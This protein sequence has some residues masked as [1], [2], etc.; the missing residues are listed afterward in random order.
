MHHFYL[1]I[2]CSSNSSIVYTCDFAQTFRWS[3]PVATN[4]R[5]TSELAS[6]S[7]H[8][9]T[10]PMVSSADSWNM[11]TSIISCSCFACKVHEYKVCHIYSLEDWIIGA[12]HF[13]TPIGLLSIYQTTES[14]W[15]PQLGGLRWI[16]AG[17]QCLRPCTDMRQFSRETSHLSRFIW[18]ATR[19][20]HPAYMPS[21]GLNLHR[22]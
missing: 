20:P 2:Y 15:Q 9:T 11:K 13:T 19:L 12:G 21:S 1:S 7:L 4:P 16:H 10:C 22:L 14:C 8:R 5:S 3:F 17:W 6:T 18:Q